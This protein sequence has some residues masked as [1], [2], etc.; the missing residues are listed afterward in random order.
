MLL[1]IGHFLLSLLTLSITG[2][3]SHAPMPHNL[4]M[5]PHEV[6]CNIM[7]RC[8][9][10]RAGKLPFVLH[11]RSGKTN[12]IAIITY[13]GINASDAISRKLLSNILTNKLSQGCGAPTQASCTA[14]PSNIQIHSPAL[15]ASY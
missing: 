6:R 12:P 4:P 10:R 1:M 2:L 15:R 13:G 3:R 11:M 5:G 14:L 9:L 8:C 7:L